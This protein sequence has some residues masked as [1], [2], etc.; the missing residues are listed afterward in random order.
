MLRLLAVVALVMGVVLIAACTGDGGPAPS[1][2]PSGRTPAP[3]AGK[4]A[5]PASKL[6][7]RF[8]AGAEGRY[9]YDYTGP[10]GDFT[11]G[12]YTLYR[13]GVND[14]HDWTTNRFGFEATTVTI[15]GEQENYVCTMTPGYNACRVARVPEIQSLR[16][17]FSPVELAMIDLATEP[18]KYEVQELG[19]ETHG[20]L[21]GQCYRA[22]SPT[23]VG[24]GPPAAE[25]IK[26]C[27]SEAGAILYFERKTTPES[28]S[29]EPFTYTLE[30]REALQ[31]TAA[32][33]QPVGRVQ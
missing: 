3:T 4:N 25:D 31:A 10:L 5:G 28:P 14:R 15:L 12:V 33:F 13:Q 30:L 27:F 9:V 29:I 26:V 16:V 23:R 20:G 1:P 8:L 6:A 11:E 2:L 24:E 19:E 22:T 17:Y 18:G 7:A 32:D 21:T